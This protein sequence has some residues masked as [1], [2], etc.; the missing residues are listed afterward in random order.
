M[1][2]TE[3][4]FHFLRTRLD[5]SSGTSSTDEELLERFAV[6]ADVI[7]HEDDG[8]LAHAGGCPTAGL[9]SSRPINSVS[10]FMLTGLLK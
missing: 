4:V 10:N 3:P 7:D 5:A 2:P 6:G 8:G 1:P 9:G